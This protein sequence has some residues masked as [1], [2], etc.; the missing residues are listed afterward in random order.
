MHIRDK[1]HK[2]L[3]LIIFV[4]LFLVATSQNNKK[5]KLYHID[6]AV[7]VTN[8]GI[9]II[10][11]FTLG[12]P[13]AIFDLSVG[14][15]KLSF[16]PQF[17]FDI[18][19]LRPWAFILWWRYKLANKEKFQMHVGAHPAWMFHPATF[20][21]DGVS[22]Q[23]WEARRFLA[24]EISP[25][26][27]LTKHFSLKPYYLYGHGFDR[28][29][30]NTHYLTMRGS[31]SDV[32]ITEQFQFSLMP[33]MYY[34]RMDENDGFYFASAFSLEHKK[35]PVSMGAMIN[36]KIESEIDSK[37]FIWNISLKYSFGK[38]YVEI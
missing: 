17:R 29:L 21:S 10:P 12:Q 25:S 27:D 16:E 18:K 24:V 36:E 28:G 7:T 11:S 15:E 35:W 38:K 20:E 31:I 6:G 9:S 34:L 13:A 23:G 33:E 37:D 14:N 4:H 19:E 26:I 30:N 22:E 2:S 32:R 3:V 5:E 8:N 1:I